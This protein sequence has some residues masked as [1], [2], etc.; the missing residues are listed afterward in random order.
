MYKER[1]EK[2]TETGLVSRLLLSQCFP[3]CQQPGKDTQGQSASSTCVERPVVWSLIYPHLI[4]K[5]KE[6]QGK[7]R[8][9]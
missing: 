8:P 2:H 9:V 1:T 4:Y 5:E 6:T 3:T 7:Q